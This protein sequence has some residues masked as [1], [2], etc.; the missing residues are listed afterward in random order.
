LESKKC[1][2]FHSAFTP[3]SRRQVET[4]IKEEKQRPFW[5]SA[6]VRRKSDRKFS[7]KIFYQE[8]KGP[9]IMNKHL[10]QLVRLS[11]IDKEINSFEP[12]MKKIREKLDF[13]V[14]SKEE[15]EKKFEVL[16]NDISDIKEKR[17][18]NEIHIADKKTK[19]DEISK[20]GTSVTTEKEV[21]AL[22]IEEEIAREQIEFAS[23]EIIRLDELL[24]KK[25]EELKEIEA[26][27]AEENETI[28]ELESSIKDEVEALEAGRI[29]LSEE[30]VQL[31]SQ[32]DN[33]IYTFYEK[34]KKWA[35]D[36]TVVPVK[37]QACYGCYMKINDTTYATV[38]KSEG[39]ITC[40]HCGRILYVP[41]QSEEIAEE[42]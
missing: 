19:L 41:E 28:T 33:K 2:F 42:A 3:N 31:A 17:S 10:K 14:A 30:K 22:Q 38:V 37:K 21:K 7:A 36:T 32:I 20:K 40:P 26:E 15:L 11:D 35:E 9:Y 4:C 24:T 5:V 39:I 25:E 12:K 23:D 34:V 8:S 13:F 16:T 1:D 6:G 27:I 29:K 18:K